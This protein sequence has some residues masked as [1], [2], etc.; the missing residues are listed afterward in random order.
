MFFWRCGSRWQ[1]NL[2]I[3]KSCNDI[4]F[5]IIRQER[6]ECIIVKMSTMILQ[7][8]VCYIQLFDKI[9]CIIS[10]IFSVIT[11]FKCL[12][13]TDVIR[14]I[15]ILVFLLVK[16]WVI[17]V[18]SQLRVLVTSECLIDSFQTFLSHSPVFKNEASGFKESI[19]IWKMH[20]QDTH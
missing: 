18:L 15:V 1:R 16:S 6:I 4:H 19:S 9:L 5:S 8:I 7:I 3:Q 11:A 2:P 10:T 17:Q 14:G 13:S 12:Y 20:P